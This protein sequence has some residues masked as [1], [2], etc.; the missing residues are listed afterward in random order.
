MVAAGGLAA[1]FGG[2]PPNDDGPI[3]EDIEVPFVWQ[4]LIDAAHEAGVLDDEGA[5]LW[6]RC[7]VDRDERLT[8]TWPFR[9]ED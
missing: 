6:K 8:S 7:V 4:F 9:R 2:D 1:I 5:T 3:P